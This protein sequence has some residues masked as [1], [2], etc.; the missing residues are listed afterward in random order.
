[1]HR[2]F[3]TSDASLRKDSLKTST[4]PIIQRHLAQIQEKF[5]EYVKVTERGYEAKKPIPK[6]VQ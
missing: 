3:T 2:L 5:Q 6:T 1:V 4:D